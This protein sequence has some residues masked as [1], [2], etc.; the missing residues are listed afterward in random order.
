MPSVKQIFIYLKI[1][2]ST[3]SFVRTPFHAPYPE[4]NFHCADA[5]RRHTMNYIFI[6]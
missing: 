5:Y 3:D 6:Y 2:R 1:K 4:V